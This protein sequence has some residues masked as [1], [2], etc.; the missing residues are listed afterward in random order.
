MAI[1]N[2]VL[3]HLPMAFLSRV[4]MPKPVLRWLSFVP[5]SVMGALVAS[6]V[7]RP[8]GEWVPPLTNPGIY[9]AILAALVFRFTRSFLGATAAGVLA[10]I[11][12]RTML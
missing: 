10:F 5:I 2:F 7:L 6:E 9:G 4:R 11:A 3:R 8:G 1:I 12:L